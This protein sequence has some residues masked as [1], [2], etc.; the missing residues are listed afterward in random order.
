[1]A[2]SEGFEPSRRFPAYTLSRRAPSTTRPSVRGAFLSLQGRA[3]A[4]G[5]GKGI[6]PWGRILWPSAGLVDM[7]PGQGQDTWQHHDGFGESGQDRTVLGPGK[8]R[9]DCLRG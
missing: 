5:N 6:W 1:M 2:D 3:G 9:A 8:P 7:R 4:R